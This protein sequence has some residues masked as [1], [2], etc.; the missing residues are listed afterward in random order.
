MASKADVIDVKFCKVS[1][2]AMVAIVCVPHR[3]Q[4]GSRSSGTHAHPL[5]GTCNANRRVL[6]F[7]Y[8]LCARVLE[9]LHFPFQV[10][11]VCMVVEFLQLH[12]LLLPV[13]HTLQE[14]EVQGCT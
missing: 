7:K 8:Q 3:Y 11:F 10:P 4:T 1:S 9:L 5:I 12:E 13:S 6:H 2:A 14:L